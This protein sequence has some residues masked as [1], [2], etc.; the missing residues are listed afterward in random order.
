MSSDTNFIS[1][2]TTNTQF[3]TN[4][5]VEGGVVNSTPPVI[6]HGD[7]GLTGQ[8]VLNQLKT[9]EDLIKSITD[10]RRDVDKE[11]GY[12]KAIGPQVYRA[13]W[14]R[15]G[16]AK[17]I[18]NLYAEESW[19]QD[20]LV[21]EDEGADLTD[22]E[23]RWQDIVNDKQVFHYLG[24]VDAISGIGRF[25]GLLI[26]VDDG[27]QLYE[28]VD[29]MDDMEDVPLPG[30]TNRSVLYLR[31]FDET[32]IQV[33]QYE[34]DPTS[35]RF[36]M[37]KL[38]KINV[39]VKDG[40]AIS[41]TVHWHRVLHVSDNDVYAQPRLQPVYNRLYDLRKILAGSGEMFWKG[42]FPGIAFEV[43]PNL[44]SPEMDATALRQEFWAYQNG[45]QRYLAVE[46]VTAKSLPVQVA[47]PKEHVE[48]LLQA[49]AITTGIPL[50]K[51]IGS[52]QAQLAS[53]QDSKTWNARLAKTQQK[54]NTPRVLR[55]F[56]ER[57]I[58]MGIMQRVEYQIEWPDLN[59]STDA[60]RAENLKMVTEALAKYASTPG[61]STLI[62]PEQFLS[63][64]LDMTEEQVKEILEAAKKQ[65]DGTADIVLTQPGNNPDDGGQDPGQGNDQSGRGGAADR[66]GSASDSG[67]ANGGGGRGQRAG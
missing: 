55:P 40:T 10:P 63:I 15:H 43:D 62:P 67:G 66:G 19:A 35:P 51:L 8:L 23:Q 65:I 47:S 1:V 48:A 39:D 57:L 22:W 12:P 36:G 29:G 58:N 42:A 2:V 44:T 6:N 4:A 3:D 9:R 49:I 46:G 59:V 7:P 38:Y 21:F 54:H 31:A 16:I 14:E 37:P 25:G 17:R 53:S 24:Q 28:P 64:F 11:C 20:P 32:K 50:R 30:G 45:L 61:L 18:C 13:M 41:K 34:E 56:I 5:A 52:E 26:G 33:S 60:E 27:R